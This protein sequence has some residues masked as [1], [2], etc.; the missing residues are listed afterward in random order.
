MKTENLIKWII[1]IWCAYPLASIRSYFSLVAPGQF[2]WDICAV[3]CAVATVVVII[4]YLVFKIKEKQQ[5]KFEVEVYEREGSEPYEQFLYRYVE[6]QN[7][8]ELE[9]KEILIY[10]NIEKDAYSYQVFN[11]G[12]L[13][14]EKSFETQTE[15]LNEKIIAGQTL[16]EAWQSIC[17][18]TVDGII[19]NKAED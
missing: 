13:I 6:K 2:G 10:L 8:C 9:Y 3:I 1:L 11:N 7:E 18:R 14:K 19:Y 12:E 15:L 4:V 16:E 17:F 5:K